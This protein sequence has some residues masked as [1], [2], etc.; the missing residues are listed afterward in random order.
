M[1]A[2]SNDWKVTSS[3]NFSIIIT[4]LSIMGSKSV[5]NVSIVSVKLLTTGFT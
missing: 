2:S 4:K 5:G 1:V 3:S